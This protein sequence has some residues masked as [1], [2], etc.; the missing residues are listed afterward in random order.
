[1]GPR[2]LLEPAGA[3][4][5]LLDVGRT[6][7]TGSPQI[8]SQE[9]STVAIQA[10]VVAVG[11][12]LCLSGLL[13]LTEC[14]A[15]GVQVLA[16]APGRIVNAKSSSPTFGPN[17]HAVHQ[18]GEKSSPANVSDDKKS[19]I[20]GLRVLYA[21]RGLEGVER[22]P[23]TGYTSAFLP[24]ALTS[25]R[26][27][28]SDTLVLVF[29]IAGDH[30]WVDRKCALVGVDGTEYALIGFAMSKSIGPGRPE[31]V[32]VVD[33]STVGAWLPPR[34]QNVGSGV[35]VFTL[36]PG[37]QRVSVRQLGVPGVTVDVR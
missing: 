1:M 28:D 24:L 23:T 7:I 9:D 13:L 36:P 29:D 32:G 15:N 19:T 21:K 25:T 4:F 31:N 3:D 18:R 16:A 27:R 33:G 20:T 22:N 5:C 30:L 11:R 14:P 37:S 8:A 12:V 10:R 34:S 35:L 17:V 2:A 26:Q 6:R